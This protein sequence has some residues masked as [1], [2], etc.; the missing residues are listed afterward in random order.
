[1]TLSE[2]LSKLIFK[3]KKENLEQQQSEK[4]KLHIVDTLA[5]ALTAYK[6]SSV[7]LKAIEAMTV[8]VFGGAGK[9]LWSEKSLPPAYAA[10]ANTALAHAMDFDDI[11]DEA[12]IHPTPVTL[13]AAL[14]VSEVVEK[15]EIE[16]TKAIFIGNEVFCRLGLALEP[17]GVGADAN[18][19]L[20]Q[21]FGY[22]SAAITAGLVLNLT[23]EELVHAIGLAYMQAAG[24]K[25][26]GVGVGSEA[27]AI[28]PAFASMG[29]VQAALLASQGVT[30]PKTSLDGHTGLF[31]IYLDGNLSAEQRQVLL[32]PSMLV[33]QQTAIKF[34]PTCRY[35]HPYIE[36]ALKLKE[37]IHFSSIQQIII[38]VNKTASMLCEPLKE[39][40]QPRTIQDAK[41]S[42]PFLVAFSFI[43]GQ[44]TLQNFTAN[45]LADEAI[46]SL[47]RCIKIER[48]EENQIG[49]PIGEMEVWTTEEKI[50][51][52]KALSVKHSKKAVLEKLQ[53]CI[54]YMELDS[55]K[56]NLGEILDNTTFSTVSSL[57]IVD[58]EEVN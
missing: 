7:A 5:I 43:Y 13:A 35:S 46:L 38:K 21:L 31:E 30:A 10:F 28:Y 11:H 36:V 14:A 50:K 53:Q 51:L 32:A 58:S 41:F 40:I 56:V 37:G 55:T 34:F 8:G 42:I 44:P 48:S 24:G 15:P 1:M 22:I 17:K 4:I 19:F 39:R 23:E 2:E 47:A 52:K 12:R 29:G 9:V 16:L 25:E 57:R 20:S 45:S 18:W 27:R 33:F 54:A 49:I 6:G 26:A 3:W